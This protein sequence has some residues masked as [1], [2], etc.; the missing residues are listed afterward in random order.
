MLIFSTRTVSSIS[1]V[2]IEGNFWIWQSYGF[3]VVKKDTNLEL[4]DASLDLS[5]YKNLCWPDFE[6]SFYQL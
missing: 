4:D 2:Q 5:F 3:L 1:S 6:E